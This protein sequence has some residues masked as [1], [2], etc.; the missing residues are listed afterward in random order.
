MRTASLLFQ[1]LRLAWRRQPISF[2]AFGGDPP[3]GRRLFFE[4][5]SNSLLKNRLATMGTW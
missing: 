4:L 2:R 1:F 5:R 3:I